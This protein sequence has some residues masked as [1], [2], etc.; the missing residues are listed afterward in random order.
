MD[1]DQPIMVGVDDP[2]V[3][4]M[5]RHSSRPVAMVRLCWS[6]ARSEKEVARH[7]RSGLPRRTR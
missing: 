7:V 1:N 6:A 4:S 2:R 3:R 5:L